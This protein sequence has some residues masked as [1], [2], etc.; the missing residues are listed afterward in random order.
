MNTR[1]VSVGIIGSLLVA[2]FASASGVDL[3]RSQDLPTPAVPQIT[4]PVCGNIGANTTW[5]LANSPYEVCLGG[6]TVMPTI[7]LTIEPGVTV[8]FVQ[9]GGNK[10]NVNYGG[11]LT[12]IGTLTQPI[13]FTGV[14]ATPG[15]WGG[16]SAFATLTPSRITLSYVTLDY[17]GLDVTSGA[18]V[19]AFNTGVTITHS[20][21]RN[22]NGNG[23][24]AESNSP[25][26][27]IHD[28]DFLSNTRSAILLNQ[29]SNRDILMSGLSASAN[30][31]NGV[32]VEGSTTLIGQHRWANI[33]VPYVVNGPILNGAGD[34]FTID[35]GS[36]LQFG[37]AG[38]LRISGRLTAIGLPNAPITLTG[39]VK[40]PGHWQGLVVQAPVIDQASMEL[41]YATVEYG[42]SVSAGANIVVGL[43]GQLVVR[44]STIR[45]SAKDG[46][47]NDVSSSAISLLNSQIVSNTLYGVRNQFPTAAILASNNWWGDPNG[48][49]TDTPACSTG[50]GDKVTNGVIFR[51]VLTDALMTRPFPLTN[52][53]ILT[54]APRRWF[55]PADGITKVYFDI[56]LR[57]PD[58]APMPGRV[59]RLSAS[60]GTVTDGGITDLNGKASAYLVSGTVGEVNLRAT[61]DGLGPC[62]NAMSPK[63]RVAFNPPLNITA[64]F[65][66]SPASYFSD[67]IS[68]T[69]MPV[70]VGITATIHSKMTNPLSVPITVDVA[71]GYAQ[72]SIGLAFGPISDIVGQVI[73]PS[74]SVSLAAQFIP[75]VSGHFCVEVSYSGVVGRLGRKCGYAA[76]QRFNASGKPGSMGTPSD[77][78]VLARAD[79]AF[80][81][82]SKLPATGTHVQKAIIGGWWGWAKNSA[83][84]IA[85]GLGSD[86][87][88]QDYNQATLPVLR[89]WPAVIPGPGVSIT[90]A[91]AMNAASD[92]LANVDA[93]GIAATTALDRYA[94]A[95]EA[96][97]LE[98]AAQ[99]ANARIFYQEKMGEA[100]LIY[101]SALE[102][103]A[104]VLV[105]EGET[106]LSV[107]VGDVIGYQQRLTSTGFTVQEIADAHLVG[108]TD[109]DIET[110][111][112]GI[113]SANPADLAG[114]LLVIYAGEAAISREWGRAMLAPSAYE[115]GLSISGSP[116][117]KPSATT[118]NSLAQI[119][120]I[121]D[122]F[123]LGNPL[124][125]TVMIDLRAR[126]IALP[127]DWM[128]NV[129]PA[130]VSLAPGEQTTVT[131]TIVPGSPTPQGTIPRLAV[132]G[133]VGSLLLG[134]VAINIV[135]PAYVDFAPY[136]AYGP[137]I[138][139]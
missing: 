114:D 49:T 103:F 109:A 117:L 94:G 87:P 76:R 16:I 56:T 136:H 124:T 91:N 31:V 32:T 89:T 125:T 82:V 97:N 137:V 64:L 75:M 126:R 17:G 67:D 100:L 24:L 41:D 18:Q 57:D 99:Q 34:G 98:W 37:A 105:N 72:S 138:R 5:T 129:T 59:T 133:Y 47:R 27:N 51:P 83:L 112:Q 30:G 60:L 108:L 33:G 55:A 104:Q 21:I 38:A 106:G 101:A 74:S 48:P 22:G 8:Q 12:A 39:R 139:R 119:N 9:G 77:K 134:G 19:Y 15:S 29:P 11:T 62:E 79:K 110:Y 69:P 26:I 81:A 123:V 68:I 113:L 58:G 116:G 7:T 66:D 71:F 70:I 50:H 118:S 78:E 52:A 2:A 4:T 73:P 65:P 1:P 35:P 102:D 130:Q 92:A 44:H 86:P 54:M 111:R 80:N 135:V 120:T 61:L 90:R 115:G 45:F 122:S 6:V 14:V 107:S 127:A 36:E 132:E 23:V 95:S 121:E 28:T 13:T 128:V 42:G 93:F 10:L 43:G 131:V 3:M 53:P 40:T 63:A 88:R 96:S 85:I 25:Q 20:L 46:V 84:G